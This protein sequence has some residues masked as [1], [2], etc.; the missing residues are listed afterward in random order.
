ML[1]GYRYWPFCSVKV[2]SWQDSLGQTCTAGLATGSQPARHMQG[3]WV[4]CLWL[5]EGKILC[6]FLEKCQGG[7]VDICTV[8]RHIYYISNGNYYLQMR[9]T[10]LPAL[11]LVLPSLNRVNLFIHF[12]LFNRT[13]WS[14]IRPVIIRV[15]IRGETQTRKNPSPRPRA[16]M[17]WSSRML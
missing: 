16:P 5:I 8:F 6:I 4:G 2:L 9:A 14:L 17:P 1:A 7:C 15:Q 12:I 13:E 11:L 10:G 3:G